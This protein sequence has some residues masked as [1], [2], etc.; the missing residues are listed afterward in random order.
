MS[1]FDWILAVADVLFALSLSIL[2]VLHLRW[3]FSKG[4]KPWTKEDDARW[5]YWIDK[6]AYERGDLTAE[7]F[8]GKYF[9]NTKP[10]ATATGTGAQGKGEAK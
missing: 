6:D 9:P 3:R 4:Y 10:V 8:F 5:Q 7:K 2:L 1:T